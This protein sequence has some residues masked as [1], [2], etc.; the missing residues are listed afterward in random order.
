MADMKILA[1]W[2][3]PVKSMSGEP[4]EAVFVSKRGLTGDRAYALVDEANRTVGSAKNAKRF[5]ELLKWQVRFFA[6][7]EPNAPA[8]PVVMTLPDGRELVSSD[9]ATAS[10]LADM[11]GPHVSLVSSAPEGLMMQIAAGTLGGKF[12]ATTEIPVSGGA[13]PGTL[14]NYSPVHLITTSTLQKLQSAY[15]DGRFAI[16]RFRPNF[17]VDCEAAGFPENAWV[18]RELAVGPE[19]RLRLTIP[20]PRCVVPTLPRRDLPPDPEILRTIASENRIHLGD[21]G[22]L[23]CAG[24]YAEVVR[25]GNVRRGDSLRLIE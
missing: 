2:R 4:L 14:F 11:F 24:V 6:T 13:P 19:V 3:Y 7:P 1:V 18:G 15:P 25:E 8:P 16:E 23:P 21:F 22:N 17:V 9:S 12:A 10:Q 5:G 20:C